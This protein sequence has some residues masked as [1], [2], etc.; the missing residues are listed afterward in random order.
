MV[1]SRRECSQTCT[2][3]S[4][5]HPKCR[6]RRYTCPGRA[7]AAVG[8]RVVGELAPTPT[9]SGG[10]SVGTLAWSDCYQEAA[11]ACNRPGST[12]KYRGGDHRTSLAPAIPGAHRRLQQRRGT[13]AGPAGDGDGDDRRSFDLYSGNEMATCPNFFL[14][15]FALQSHLHRGGRLHHVDEIMSAS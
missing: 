3:L 14:L 5:E 10:R 9:E 7:S 8:R 11:D 4:A 1:H 13:T 15:L 2:H 12:G 6:C